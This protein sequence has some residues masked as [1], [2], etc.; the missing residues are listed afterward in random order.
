M[1]HKKGVEVIELIGIFLGVILIIVITFQVMK[2]IGGL[3]G[4]EKQSEIAFNSLVLKINELLQNPSPIA[5]DK[6]T[7]FLGPDKALIAFAKGPVQFRKCGRTDDATVPIPATPACSQGTCVC[8]S[9]FQRQDNQ[10]TPK[11]CRPLSVETMGVQMLPIPDLTKATPYIIATQGKQYPLSLPEEYNIPHPV[12]KTSRMPIILG[13]CSV[14]ESTAQELA[15]I[16]VD[17]PVKTTLFAPLFASAALLIPGG[18]FFAAA[19]QFAAYLVSSAITPFAQQ[20]I[21]VEKIT[22]PDER[23]FLIIDFFEEKKAQ[24]RFNNLKERTIDYDVSI[25]QKYAGEKKHKQAI[26]ALHHLLRIP[27]LTKE[28]LFTAKSL[29]CTYANLNKE[30]R[31]SFAACQEAIN[32]LPVSAEFFERGTRK[33]YL[34]NISLTFALAQTY[35]RMNKFIDAFE[36]YDSLLLDVNFLKEQEKTYGT[37]S[38]GGVFDRLFKELEEYRP[39]MMK[40]LTEITEDSE[41]A[42]LSANQLSQLTMMYFSSK[43]DD[44]KKLSIALFKLFKKKFPENP[45]TKDFEQKEAE[46]IH[47]QVLQSILTKEE[48]A[49]SA[50]QLKEFIAKTPESPIL[51]EFYHALV[52]AAIRMNNIELR[53]EAAKGYIETAPSMKIF[54]L[55]SHQFFLA[56]YYAGKQDLA[57]I[58]YDLAKQYLNNILLAPTFLREDKE[59]NYGI[60]TLLFNAKLLRIEL[61]KKTKNIDGAI[62]LTQNLLGEYKTTK[63][64]PLSKRQPPYDFLSDEHLNNDIKILERTLTELTSAQKELQSQ[65]QKTK[66]QILT[67]QNYR[68]AES[69]YDQKDFAAARTYYLNFFSADFS[70]T[71]ADP[72]V[73]F[74]AD[75]TCKA[76]L[77]FYYAPEQDFPHCAEYGKYCLTH[78]TTPLKQDVSRIIENCQIT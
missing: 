73:P 74:F 27:Q 71:T 41:L 62:S 36:L 46:I 42:Q 10:V 49:V 45:L 54:E 8:L 48:P 7:Y 21:Y 66:E 77:A 14:A 65:R 51:Y 11:D 47:F 44:V 2:V 30:D 15:N 20:P 70:I 9:D 38:L 13:E 28:Q 75:T 19:P 43:N 78:A 40:S 12:Y 25:A 63:E 58:N 72:L 26:Q 50:Q 68:A 57:A 18:V 3:T 61:E 24:L 52:F 31:I 67:D 59:T 23:T 34:T 6:L 4:K 39:V 60:A 1:R 35:Q 33:I 37:K 53:V 69:A 76:A 16:V 56:E 5:Y 17:N 64:L 22:L 32:L 29:L 55:L